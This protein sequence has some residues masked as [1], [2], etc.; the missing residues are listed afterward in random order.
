[1]DATNLLGCKRCWLYGIPIGAILARIFIWFCSVGMHTSP[2]LQHYVNCEVKRSQ[3][4]RWRIHK[5]STIKI[6]HKPQNDVSAPA[7]LK[8]LQFNMIPILKQE[9]T[10]KTSISSMD[11]H[12]FSWMREKAAYEISTDAKLKSIFIRSCNLGTHT[13]STCPLSPRKVWSEKNPSL[14]MKDP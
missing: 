6:H 10:A 4:W 11:C 7:L 1:M 3:A 5:V 14:E 13:S 2:A 9:W 12:K 8:L